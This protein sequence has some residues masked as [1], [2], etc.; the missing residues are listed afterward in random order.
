MPQ[1]T[2]VWYC[3][4]VA[5]NWLLLCKNK[6]EI[7]EETKALIEVCK[8]SKPTKRTHYTDLDKWIDQLSKFTCEK[9]YGYGFVNGDREANKNNYPVR[10]W[11]KLDSLIVDIIWSPHL[12]S[13]VSNHHSSAYS[14]N[15]AYIT[16]LE[17]ILKIAENPESYE[18]SE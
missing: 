1:K 7:I 17:L 9:F 6:D 18:L 4:K 11:C 16:E 15:E 13:E 5:V 14:R 2:K 10:Y 3:T 12:N 8:N